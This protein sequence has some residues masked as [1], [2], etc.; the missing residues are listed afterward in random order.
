MTSPLTPNEPID[1][2]ENQYSIL[3][4]DLVAD[5]ATIIAIW[6]TGLKQHGAPD[7][8][9]NWYYARPKGEQPR[10]YLLCYGVTRSPVGVATVG[11][12]PMRLGSDSVKGGVLVDFVATPEHRTLFPAMHLQRAVLKLGLENHDVLFGLPNPKSLAVVHRAGYAKIGM[13]TRYAMMLRSASYVARFVPESVANVI[14]PAIDKVRAL[15]HV[16][17]RIGAPQY[18]TCWAENVDGSFDQHWADSAIPGVLMGVRNASFLNWRFAASPVRKHTFFI[19]SDGTRGQLLAYAVCDIS[20]CPIG[21]DHADND[22]AETS[23]TKRKP[24]PPTLHVRDFLVTSNNDDAAQALWHLLARDAY[25]KGYGSIST[26][27]LGHTKICNALLRAGLRAREFRPL[28]AAAGADLK[29]RLPLDSWYV[30]TADED[31]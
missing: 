25:A 23:N 10:V 7:A 9:F 14:G 18:Q 26:E 12:R 13:M 4:A 11:L 21:A 30:T 8:K 28:Y 5:R 31:W 27:F 17:R 1:I 2:K 24:A 19:L 16:V 29:T 15:L 20:S 6:Y 3:E 22:R